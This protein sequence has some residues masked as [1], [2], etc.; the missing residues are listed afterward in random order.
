RNVADL[1]AVYHGAWLNGRVETGQLSAKKEHASFHELSLAT[2]RAGLLA[3]MLGSVWI[4]LQVQ[5]LLERADKREVLT[6][7]GPASEEKRLARGFG[8]RRAETGL[9]FFG[10][11]TD[12][13][14]RRYREPGKSACSAA[15]GKH[16]RAADAICFF[17]F[18]R[19]EYLCSANQSLDETTP[20]MK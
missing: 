15:P 7:Q 11:Q 17:F 8:H 10:K 1:L 3:R 12:C 4:R 13:E 14:R 20:R 5:A 16:P 2:G 6:S 9:R 18:L 19:M